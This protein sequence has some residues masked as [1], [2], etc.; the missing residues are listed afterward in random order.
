MQLLEWYN[1]Y[2]WADRVAAWDSHLA[3]ARDAEVVAI[4][5]QDARERRARDLTLINDANELASREL[6]K[7][8]TTSLQTE[9]ETMSVGALTRLLDTSIKLGRLLQG[10]STENISIQEEYDLSKLTV[11]E[12]RTLQ[13]LQEKANARRVP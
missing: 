2:L 7:C 3:Q 11:D 12:L 6:Q 8:L 4:T 1:T 5:G 10:E 13:T 9:T